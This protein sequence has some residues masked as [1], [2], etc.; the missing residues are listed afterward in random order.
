MWEDVMNDFRIVSCEASNGEDRGFR[1]CD[2]APIERLWCGGTGGEIITVDP[3][4]L[5]DVEARGA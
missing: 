3:I 2:D 1:R 5:D 4:G